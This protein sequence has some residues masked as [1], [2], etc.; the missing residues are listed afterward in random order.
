MSFALLAGERQGGK[1]TLCQQLVLSARKRGIG[2]GGIVASRVCEA[3]RTVGYDVIDL[4]TGRTLRLADTIGPGIERIGPF[5]FK[6]DGLQ[7][8]KD[9]LARAAN[10]QLGLVIVDEV[11]PL[12]LAGGGWSG[13]LDALAKRGGCTLL[14]VR[15]KLAQRVAER[16]NVPSQARFDLTQD[17]RVLTEAILE[18]AGAKGG[19]Q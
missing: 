17:S 19:G 12:E 10:Q 5:H 16:W 4:G 3:N 11:G 18:M 9:A 15:L 2:V 6:A 14:V 1:T 8:G 13:Q 7:L